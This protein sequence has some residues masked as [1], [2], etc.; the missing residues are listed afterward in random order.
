VIYV[1]KSKGPSIELKRML[2]QEYIL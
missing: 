2:C 1:T